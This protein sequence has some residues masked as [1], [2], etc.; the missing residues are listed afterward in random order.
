[1][2]IQSVNADLN[3][4]LNEG[5]TQL[6]AGVRFDRTPDGGLGATSA[7]AGLTQVTGHTT[8][9][10]VRPT[11]GLNGE[12]FSIEAGIGPTPLRPTPVGGT[13][14]Y[15]FADGSEVTFPALGITNGAAR[16][17][18]DSVTLGVQATL[19]RE[20]LSTDPLLNATP[21]LGAAVSH[22][23]GIGLQGRIEAG[24]RLSGAPVS[25]AVSNGET[26]APPRGANGVTL[27]GVLE[28][29]REGITGRLGNG[30]T[31]ADEVAAARQPLPAARTDAP[32]PGDAAAD[33]LR[34]S[35]LYRQALAQLNPSGA[36]VAADGPMDRVAAAVAVQ[37][38]RDGLTR[39]AALVPGQQPGAAG[40]SSVLFALDGD[41]ANPASQRVAVDRFRAETVPV[42]DAARQ[43]AAL[44]APTPVPTPGPVQGESLQPE[45][46]RRVQ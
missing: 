42:A 2:P 33:A 18:R 24:A 45:A 40:S 30:S 27:T 21:V 35:P 26:V 23:D 43:F 37:G 32:P 39:V 38:A 31:F 46:S 20:T 36:P 44:T 5:Q 9:V 13:Q 14:S 12:S 29:N 8:Q 7:S 3:A 6:G 34:A 15:T 22:I 4:V 25:A 10:H 28:A 17:L 41:P 16:P 11:V 19:Q 1:M